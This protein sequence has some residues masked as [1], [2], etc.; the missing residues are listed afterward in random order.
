[1]QTIFKQQIDAKKERKKSGFSKTNSKVTLNFVQF[2]DIVT[3]LKKCPFLDGIH[4]TFSRLGLA[5]LFYHS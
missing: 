5:V 4:R 3:H 2:Q 1:M